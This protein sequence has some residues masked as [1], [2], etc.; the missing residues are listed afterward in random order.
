[1][2]AFPT[3]GWKVTRDRSRQNMLR[4]LGMQKSYS[5]LCG[6]PPSFDFS[7]IRRRECISSILS[8]ERVEPASSRTVSG[9]AYGRHDVLGGLPVL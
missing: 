9:Q 1:M 2:M 4:A 3:S 5:L 6:L 8:V 7:R